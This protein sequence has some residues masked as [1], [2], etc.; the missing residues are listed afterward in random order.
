[1]TPYLAAALC[2][3]AAIALGFVASNEHR[4]RRMAER[5]AHTAR[6]V[7]TYR[8]KTID[9]LAHTAGLY[10]DDR[11]RARR[12]AEFERTMRYVA[13]ADVETFETALRGLLTNLARQELMEPDE[14]AGVAD[15]IEM[16]VPLRGLSADEADDLFRSDA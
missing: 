11:D 4:K 14:P 15:V 12:D 9:A 1:M 5:D 2:L 8:Q 13:E 3:L 7:A 6:T 16:R 10:L